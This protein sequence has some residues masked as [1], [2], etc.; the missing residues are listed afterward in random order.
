LRTIAEGDGAD[1]WEAGGLSAESLEL[2]R[3]F[4]YAEM[5]RESAAALLWYVRNALYFELGL[6][7][8]GDVLLM[9]YERVVAEPEHHMRTL[10]EFLS[11]PFDARMAA[12]IGPRPPAREAVL[13]ID[14]RIWAQCVELERRLDAAVRSR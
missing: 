13:D 6:D 9:S 14:G 8:R 7:F 3:S 11:L 5:S 4:D 12:I 1:L 2:I 10:C